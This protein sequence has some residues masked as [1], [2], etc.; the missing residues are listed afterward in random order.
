MGEQQLLLN[1]AKIAGIGGL[2]L[3]VFFLLFRKI[4]RKEIISTLGQ[5]ESFWVILVFMVLVWSIAIVGMGVWVYMG[6]NQRQQTGWLKIKAFIDGTDVLTITKDTA[7]WSHKDNISNVPGT[8]GNNNYPT[9]INDGPYHFIFTNGPREVGDSDV[10]QILP[11]IPDEPFDILGGDS[12]SSSGTVHVS[13]PLSGVISIKIIK[14]YKLPGG[15]KW[16]DVEIPWK[17]K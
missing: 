6:L 16:F 4:I 17:K 10:V 3:G 9:D 5:K 2:A 14:P 7:Q 12:D 13:H 1:L 11:A 15:A 8:W